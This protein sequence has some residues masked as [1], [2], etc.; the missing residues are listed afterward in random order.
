MER[1]A[2]L[3]LLRSQHEFPGLFLFRVVVRPEVT[4]AVL[5]AMTAAAGVDGRV[6]EVNQ[7]RSSKGTYVALHVNMKLL[8]AEV[9]LDVYGVLHGMDG[10]M[11]A[12]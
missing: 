10:V 11:T 12:L 6:H 9:V 5:G 2:A 8:R 4:D 1:E 7:R 3:E